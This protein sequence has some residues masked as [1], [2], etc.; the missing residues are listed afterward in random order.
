MNI[1]TTTQEI[2]EMRKISVEL[3]LANHEQACPTCPQS[4]SCQLQDLARQLGVE[5]RA[6]QERPANRCPWTSPRRR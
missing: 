4:A 1:S 6:V 5:K 2:R 3:L